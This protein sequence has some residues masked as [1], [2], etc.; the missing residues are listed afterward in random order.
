MYQNA[1]KDE[2]H[3]FSESIS[4]MVKCGMKGHDLMHGVLTEWENIV[5]KGVAKNVIG[6]KFMFVVN[7]F[8]G[9]MM[10]LKIKLV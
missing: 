6:E 2:V 5:N 7:Q 8:V 1:L 4:S 3:R 10:K 9:G